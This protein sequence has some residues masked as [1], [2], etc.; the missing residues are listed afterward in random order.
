MIRFLVVFSLITTTIFGKSDSTVIASYHRNAI[1][2]AAGSFTDLNNWNAGG[3]NSSN[4][5]LLLRENWTKKGE[6]F[7]TVHLL[8]GNYGLSRQ[9]GILTKNADKLEFTTTLAGS[10]KTTAWNL[11]GQ[12]NV[13]TQFAPGF[14][15]GDTTRIPVSTFGAPVYGQYSFGI[16]NNSWEHWQ[17][18]LSPFAGKSTTVFDETLREKGAFGVDT[19]ATWRFEAGAKITLNYTQQ[20][21]DEFGVTAKSDLFFNY[22]ESIS[23]TDLNLDIIAIYKIRKA[24][25]FNAHFQLIRDIDQ[26]DAWQRRS[27]LGVG[28]AY[29]IK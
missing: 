24:L 9:A 16:G 7:T 21:T 5:S 3:E 25:S 28:L 2:S 1:Y 20:L 18:F 27:V 12:L 4:I 22:W 10:S 8:E 13:R 15:K 19:G 6:N 29:T 23:A 11:S 26:I 14:A 17:V